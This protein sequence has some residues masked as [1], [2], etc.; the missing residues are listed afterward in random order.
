MLKCYAKML[1]F[2]YKFSC[3]FLISALGANLE[4][5]KIYNAFVKDKTIITMRS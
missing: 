2:S 5:G 3:D 1:K 4:V